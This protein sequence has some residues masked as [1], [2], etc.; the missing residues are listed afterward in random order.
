MRHGNEVRFRQRPVPCNEP[1]AVSTVWTID[2][3]ESFHG[4]WSVS[5][6]FTRRRWPVMDTRGFHSSAVT[7]RKGKSQTHTHSVTPIMIKL[8][9]TSTVVRVPQWFRRLPSINIGSH[10]APLPSW[11]LPS[12]YWVLSDFSHVLTS[13]IGFDWFILG[14]TKF[15]R[16]CTRFDRVVLGFTA[17]YRIFPMFYQVILNL[18]W[19]YWVLYFYTMFY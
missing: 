4:G 8:A 12:F 6:R 7:V 16:C 10:R 5:L 11:D 3:E 15:S 13:F 1:R 14:F 2:E 18:T 9:P 17:L 19:F